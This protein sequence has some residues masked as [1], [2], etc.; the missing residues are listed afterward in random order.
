MDRPKSRNTE[1]KQLNLL[2]SCRVIAGF[3]ARS[4]GAKSVDHPAVTAIG[5]RYSPHILSVSSNRGTIAHL[6]YGKVAFS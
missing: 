3:M 5:G 1:H 4:R 6:K 2:A